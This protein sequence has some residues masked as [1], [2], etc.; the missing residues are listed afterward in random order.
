MANLVAIFQGRPH[1]Y[2]ILYLSLIPI[3][4]TIYYFFPSI[5]G[6]ERS[7]LECL[8]FSTVT[9][10]TLGYGDI[11]PLD[12]VGQIVTASEALLGVVAIGLFL[13]AIASAR[14]DTVRKEEAERDAKS[15]RDSQQARLNGHYSLI[16]P[17]VERYRFFAIVITCPTGSDSRQYNPNFSLNDMKDLYKPSGLTR[18]RLLKPAIVGYFES[19]E[20]LHNEIS[21]LVKNVD[22]RCFP[23]IETYSLQLMG[24]ITNFDYSGFILSAT[25]TSAE[26]RKL[27]EIAE[28]MLEGYSGN[29][30]PHGANL[31]D[32]YIAL[33]Y[34]IKNIMEILPNLER[35]IRT[36]TE[37]DT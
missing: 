12:E 24:V 9:I 5:I 23:N 18:E 21:D 22:L 7:Y 34:Q 27:S 35:E 14:S 10:T 16:R 4:A 3:Y 11:I 37:S 6:S 8:Y 15:Y 17:I 29:Y 30:Q 31:I 2:G 25:E 1:H 26:D 19:I 28:E 33:Y 20:D 32:A 13:N 36:E